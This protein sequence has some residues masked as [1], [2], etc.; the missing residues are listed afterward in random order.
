LGDEGKETMIKKFRIPTVFSEG[1]E[2]ATTAEE[3]SF[4]FREAEG[5]VGGTEALDA[6]GV[7]LAFFGGGSTKPSS[8][9]YIGW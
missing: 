8:L 6:A 9:Q 5:T 1:V 2:E 7:A 3:I 4:S